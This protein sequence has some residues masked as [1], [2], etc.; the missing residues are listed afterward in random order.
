VAHRG[1]PWQLI[2]N[3]SKLNSSLDSNPQPN[4][5]SHLEDYKTLGQIENLLHSYYWKRLLPTQARR[6]ASAETSHNISLCKSRSL[7]R[8]QPYSAW[9]SGVSFG[10]WVPKKITIFH[11]RR[12]DHIRLCHNK[13]VDSELITCG[14]CLILVQICRIPTCCLFSPDLFSNELPSTESIFERRRVTGSPEAKFFAV[15]LF[16][17]KKF[18]KPL[19]KRLL[20]FQTL[21]LMIKTEFYWL[22]E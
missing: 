2:I 18:T 5:Q 21:P 7:F 4:N 9:H 15:P 22:A 10:N 20:N 3:A 16:S 6:A 1:L 17:W 19:W 11:G 13:A 12:I 14:S 8:T